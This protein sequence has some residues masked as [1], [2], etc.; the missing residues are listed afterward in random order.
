MAFRSFRF[1][2]RVDTFPPYSQIKAGI[3]YIDRDRFLR[4]LVGV[5]SPF[6][7]LEWPR[8]VG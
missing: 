3:I 6:R 4:N 7:L 2:D 5:Q 8:E 1:W